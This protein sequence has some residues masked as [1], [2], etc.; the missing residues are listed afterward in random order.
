MNREC[1]CFG[2]SGLHASTFG[3]SEGRRCCDLCGWPIRGGAIDVLSAVNGTVTIPAAQ[4]AALLEAARTLRLAF[5]LPR[6]WMDGGITWSQWDEACVKIDA[7]LSALKAA[8]I[9]VEGL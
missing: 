8:G 2:D 4:H 6:P 3:D 9:D 5:R 7:A 1:E